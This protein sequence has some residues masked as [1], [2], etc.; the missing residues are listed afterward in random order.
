MA[1][2]FNYKVRRF[3]NVSFFHNPDFDEEMEVNMYKRYFQS[4]VE[5]YKGQDRT[6]GGDR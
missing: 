4:K 5:G 6:K 2:D 1:M 3:R